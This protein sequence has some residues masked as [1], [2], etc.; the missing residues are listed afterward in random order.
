MIKALHDIGKGYIKKNGSGYEY[1]NPN[2]NNK[3]NN[4]I[5]IKLVC[6]NNE[7]IYKSK[8]VKQD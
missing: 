5:K 2:P 6:E 1:E 7:V 4:V 8:I 3:Y